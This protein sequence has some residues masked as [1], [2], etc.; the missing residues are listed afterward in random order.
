MK[1]ACVYFFVF[2]ASLLLSFLPSDTPIDRLIAGFTK[3]LDEFPQEKI[4]LHLDRPY[5]ASGETIWLKAYLTAGAFH[6]PSSL[7]RTIYVELINGE[8]ELVKELRLLSINGS[9]AGDIVLADSLA[10]GNYL[11][12]AYTHWMKN[13][14]E[15]YFFHCPVK[16]WN[17]AVQS[18]TNTSMKTILDVQFFPEGGDLVNGILSKVAFKAVASDGLGR[19]IKGKIVD[20][21]GAVM[22]NFKSNF[23]GMGAFNIMPLKGKSYAA[24]IEEYLH[25]PE[26][27]LPPAKES[28]LAMSIKNSAASTDLI[29]RIETTDPTKIKLVYILAQTR[30]IVCY[31]AHMDLSAKVVIAKI[32][33]SKFP[34]GIAQIT[35]TDQ[36]GTPLAER[37]TFVNEL[38]QVSIEVTSNK[39]TYSPR[40]IVTLQIQAKLANGMPAVADLSLSV[41]DDRQVLTDENR[42]TISTYLLL[43]SELKGLIESPAYYFN[44]VNKDRAEALDHLLLT[45]GW[46]RFTFKKALDQ[47]WQPPEYRIEK[48]L[49]IKG[50]ML[51]A[52][53]NKPVSDGTVTYLSIDP[54]PFTSAVRTNSAGD[55]EL[56]DIIYFDSA[57]AVLQ[58]ETKKG[59]RLVKFMLNKEAEFPPVRF[60]RLPFTEAP[61]E[62]DSTFIVG[63]TER[64]NI[65]R[66]Y[67][68]DEKTIRLNEVVIRGQREDPP[69]TVSKTH[70][71]G[72][73]TVQVAGIPSMENQ[74]H[75]LQLLQSGVAGIQVTRGGQNWSVSVRG[76]GTPFI[77]IDEIPV[78]I[79]NLNALS[80][81]DIERVEVWKGGDAAIFGSRGGNGVI[82]FYTKKGVG[83]ITDQAISTID[84]MGYQVEREFYGPNY[85]TEKPEHIKPDKRTTLFWAPLIKTDSTGRAS[86]SFYN[87]DV[88]TTVTGIAEGI[89]VTGK[90]GSTTFKFVIRKN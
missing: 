32:P 25:Q 61:T 48:G 2:M 26:V 60:P 30:G 82:G 63:S 76:G 59:Y 74:S 35:V 43:S 85:E 21:A 19:Q 46:R 73:A 28:G 20:E 75:P 81:N 78:S 24:I 84:A 55:F 9:A 14:G 49:T 11:V 54:V 90:P 7:S 71:K 47:Q 88:E 68:F 27:K 40:E 79:E 72:S 69:N 42:E 39:T 12:R 65:D 31:A 67:N 66:A 89:S 34:S 16:I 62:F 87:N 51:D 57:K 53:T 64:R 86:V 70:G 6:L 1:R 15:D 23:L 45:Q 77:M 83:S 37:L 38:E 33:K 4:Y 8:G 3:Y 56:N 18:P 52:N 41:F 17:T 13:T 58:G 80:V 36:E 29:L 50:K 5:Y 10:S 22:C 44:P